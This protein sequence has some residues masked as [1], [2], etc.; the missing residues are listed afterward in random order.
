M[1]GDQMVLR[2]SQWC[3]RGVWAVVTRVFRVPERPPIMSGGDDH[4][5]QAFRPAEGYLRYLKLFF[6]IG[7]FAVDIALIIGWEALLFAKPYIGL[8]TAP[9]W[10]FVIV[11]PD[12]IAYIAIHLR[13]DTT[14]YVLSD[15]S[16]RI[17]R[18]IWIIRETTITYENIKSVA[19]RQGPVQRAFNIA[20]VSVETAGGGSVGKEAGAGSFGG[21]HG[22]LEGIDHA[23][24]VRDLILAKWQ[25]ARGAGLGDDPHHHATQNSVATTLTPIVRSM[26]LCSPEHLRVLK[27]IRDLAKSL[28]DGPSPASD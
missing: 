17:R 24:Q 18:G 13:Y 10:W 15:R 7:L 19:I 20:D 22:L 27:E 28:A 4:S 6:W 2:A 25:A 1:I 11:V 5:V 14:W 8:V 3:Y 9:I 12:I 26:T 23:E 16:M 21:H